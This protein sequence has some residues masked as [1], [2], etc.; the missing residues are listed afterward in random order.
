MIEAKNLC[1]SY[2]KRQVLKDFNIHIEPGQIVAVL[3]LNG[4]G[5]TSLIKS[6]LGLADYEGSLEICGMSPRKQRCQLMQNMCF[7]ADVAILPRWLKVKNALDFV[8]GVHPKFDRQKAERLIGRTN[9]LMNQRVRE[10]SK[11]MVV[12]LHLALVMAIDVDILVLDEP[13]LG[14]DMLYRKQFYR[15]LLEDYYTQQRT[16]IVA[17][18]QV[19][20]IESIVTHLV[21][22]RR[23]E[24]VLDCSMAKFSERF[25]SITVNQDQVEAIEALDPLSKYQRLGK[26]TFI[27]DVDETKAHPLL[28]TAQSASISDVFVAKMEGVEA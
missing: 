10:L 13:T 18:H 25:K 5:K 17:T 27:L 14:L 9:I 23:G 11:G 20:E 6:L 19:E 8:E 2:G 28:S 22:L 3:G 4:A 12:Q 1:K 26:T 21:M 24:K 15:H 16:I 7:I